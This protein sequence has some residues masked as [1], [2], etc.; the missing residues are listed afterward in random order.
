MDEL[1]VFSP[2]DE[3]LI[4]T[5]PLADEQV[6]ET[7]L[8]CAHQAYL[9]RDNWLPPHQRIAIL[10][11]TVSIMQDCKDKLALSAATEGGET[12][13]RFSNRSR[14]GDLRSKNGHCTYPAVIGP[15]NP[16]E[17]FAKLGKSIGLYLSRTGRGGFCH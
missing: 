9:D 14:A 17:C 15:G 5:V 4:D 16:D 12:I 10:E 3:Q 7:M 8:A 13:S 1:S 2:Y 11:K 6:I